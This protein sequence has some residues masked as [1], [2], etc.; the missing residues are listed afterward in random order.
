MV[1]R[2]I[3]P[4]VLLADSQ[5][6]FGGS[7]GETLSR[8]IVTH[9]SCRKPSAN[10][11]T[12]LYIGASNGDAPEY[13]HMA[14]DICRGWG[15]DNVKHIQDSES[16][17]C[18]PLKDI[19]VVILSG[20]DIELGWRFLSLEP[21]RAWLDAYTQDEGLLIGIS[22]GAIHLASAFSLEHGGCV[23]F[24]GYYPACIAVHEEQNGWPTEKLWRQHSRKLAEQEANSAAQG[25]KKLTGIPFGGGLMV[26]EKGTLSIGKGVKELGQID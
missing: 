18:L 3:G 15:V 12:A 19:S 22:A 11:K 8:W 23:D 4:M 13:F 26:D 17:N 9:I 16:F 6:L 14:V 20:G 1:L 7:K 2:C 21:V 24:L 25:A 10:P 5:L